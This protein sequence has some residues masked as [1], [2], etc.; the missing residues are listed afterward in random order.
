MVGAFEVLSVELAGVEGHAA[1]GTGVS[2]RKGMAYTIAS[3]NEWNLKQHGFVELIAMDTVGGQRAIPEAGEHERVR[4][5]ALGR[6][7][8]GHGRRS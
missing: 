6:I 4:R 5:L 8:F 2:Q 7:E 3:D 1:V